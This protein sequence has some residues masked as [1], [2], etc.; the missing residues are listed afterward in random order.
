M[1]TEA[2]AAAFL[3]DFQSIHVDARMR[4]DFIVFSYVIPLGPRVGEEVQVGLQV[5][6]DYPAT[7]PP[8]PHFCPRIV[9]PA[10]AVHASPLGPDWVY[11]SRP[12]PNWRLTDRSVR[13]YL[14]H[15][16]ALLAQL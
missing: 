12:F 1:I 5:P 6:A 14:A 2:G 7:P 16:R 8:G 15:I 3:R 10:G 11:W 9:H 13:T 4:S